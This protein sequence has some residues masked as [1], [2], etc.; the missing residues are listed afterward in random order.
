MI[1]LPG[2]AYSVLK[3]IW[4]GLT[5]LRGR[6]LQLRAIGWTVDQWY[7]PALAA[8]KFGNRDLL[9]HLED[10]KVAVE[11][12][13]AKYREDWQDPEKD[14]RETVRAFNADAEREVDRVTDLLYGDLRQ[15]LIRGELIARGFREP[16]SDGPPYR[17]IPCHEWRIIELVEPRDRA[18]G[19]G[20]AYIGLT[21]GKVG[22][23]S[24][25]GRRKQ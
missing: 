4:G 20:V 23:K 18:E 6:R 9:Q 21:I 22:T 24:I 3:D 14:L 7:H 11:R 17:A 15:R 8:E 2:F 1:P 16:F 12:E 10:A 19:G 13:W 25:F 5:R